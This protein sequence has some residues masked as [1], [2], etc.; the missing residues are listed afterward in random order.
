MANPPQEGT[1]KG[2]V[3]SFAIIAQEILYQRGVFYRKEASYNS[4]GMQ[5]AMY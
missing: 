3:Y 1:K 5:N 4:D 2:D